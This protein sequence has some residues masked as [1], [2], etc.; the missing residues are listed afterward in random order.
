MREEG[1]ERGESEER[2]RARIL[3]AP[4][5]NHS[6]LSVLHAEII[7]M[8]GKLHIMWTRRAKAIII[9]AAR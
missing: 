2:A 8:Q 3:S 9:S 1:E 4:S 5:G 7:R 6:G